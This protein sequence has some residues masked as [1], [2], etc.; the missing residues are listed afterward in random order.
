MSERGIPCLE[1]AVSTSRRDGESQSG[2]LYVVQELPHGALIA[3]VDGLGHGKEAAAA[4]RI[5]VEVVGS[6]CKLPIIPLIQLCHARLARTRGVVMGVA[7]LNSLEETLSWLSVGNVDGVLVR[8][9]GTESPSRKGVVMRGGVVGQRLPPL[10]VET[11][12]VAGGAILAFATDGIR[13]GFHELVTSDDDP[14]EV[15]RRILTDFGRNS[16]DALVLVARCMG[17]ALCNES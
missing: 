7:L 11:S 3:V 9:L 8:G 5:A 12:S 10:H 13:S 2:D 14:K 16:D 15:S 6:S 1:W 4:A 17:A